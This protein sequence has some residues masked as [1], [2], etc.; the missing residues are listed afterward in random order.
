LM[1]LYSS[2]DWGYLLSFVILSCVSV[3]WL[4]KNEIL[5]N[6]N[7]DRKKLTQTL[8]RRFYIHAVSTKRWNHDMLS[9][10]ATCVILCSQ[11]T[12]GLSSGFVV[13]PVFKH[14]RVFDFLVTSWWF[15]GVT[16]PGVQYKRLPVTVERPKVKEKDRQTE[17]I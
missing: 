17:L 2:P 3:R 9:N 7:V 14:R 15:H 1:S 6:V 10:R 11:W 13:Q 12:F 4:H 16:L 5:K 8:R